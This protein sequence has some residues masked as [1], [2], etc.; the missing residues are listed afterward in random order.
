[1]WCMRCSWW[2]T[3]CR[4]SRTCKSLTLRRSHLERERKKIGRRRE[5]NDTNGKEKQKHQI[6]QKGRGDRLKIGGGG[7]YT[8]QHKTRTLI[9]PGITVVTRFRS[10]GKRCS[11]CAKLARV[12]D[13][14]CQLL[15][16]SIIAVLAWRLF[17]SSELS[18]S[19][20]QACDGSS[21]V[22]ILIFTTL[23]CA[24]CSGPGGKRETSSTILARDGRSITL[25][26]E[27]ASI[28]V[29]TRR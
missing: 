19:T 29:C 10:S 7:G 14:F 3:R 25:L 9:L 15:N 1:M 5:K 20:R 17:I 4:W 8:E 13:C 27:L 16:L 22:L 12:L 18:S 11:S 6:T 21:G 24:A 28:A 26:L 23:A 2:C